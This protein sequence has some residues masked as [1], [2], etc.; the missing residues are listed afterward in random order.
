MAALRAG[1]D[2]VDHHREVLKLS[3]DFRDAELTIGLHE[4]HHRF[5][6]V[7]CEDAG[8][9]DGR[10][11]VEEAR[12]CRRLN[13]FRRKVNGR[14]TSRAFCWSISTNERSAGRM[15]LRWRASYQRNIRAIICSS[16]K[17]L[18][19]LHRRSWRCVRK[20]RRS[21]RE[22]SNEV[23]SIFNSLLRDKT[24]DRTAVDL[25]NLRL[26]LTRQ[27]LDALR[28]TTLYL[29]A[30]CFGTKHQAMTDHHNE[31]LLGLLDRIKEFLRTQ[32]Y[33][34]ETDFLRRP[35]RELMPELAAKREEVKAQ[36]SLGA[37]LADGIRWLGSRRFRSLRSSVKN[38]AARRSV[39][40]S[41][42]AR[43]PTSETWKS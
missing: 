16:C 8:C 39:T 43:R 6:A 31:E 34:L 32:V 42:T 12:A 25:V 38:W 15:R 13:E 9:N 19:R 14:A 1:T 30:L 22:V 27:Q 11:R 23:L 36:G 40:T 28:L 4:L 18:T 3:P 17:W 33:P 41:S 7:A 10:A 26:N 20:R 35:F 5:A 29:V 2:S 24:L 21:A 37:T